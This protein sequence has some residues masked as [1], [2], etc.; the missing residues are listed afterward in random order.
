MSR[1]P[2]V[3]EWVAGERLEAIAARDL[4]EVP[5]AEGFLYG[6]RAPLRLPLGALGFRV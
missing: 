4:E 1:L 5:C 6:L 3:T 2:E